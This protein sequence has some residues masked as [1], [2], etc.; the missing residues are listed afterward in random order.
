VRIQWRELTE[1]EF[2]SGDGPV[3]ARRRQSFWGGIMVSCVGIPEIL[4]SKLVNS[5]ERLAMILMI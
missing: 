4:C 3:P 1:I 5:N 2:F